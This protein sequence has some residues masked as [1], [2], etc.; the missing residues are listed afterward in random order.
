MPTFIWVFIGGGLGSICRY[1]IA[2]G[3]KSYQFTFPYATLLANVLA[4]FILGTMVGGALK[5]DI[6]LSYRLLIMTGFC[7]GFSTF[8]TFTYET[9][10]LLEQGKFTFALVNIGGSLFVCLVSIYLGLKIANNTF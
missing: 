10:A 3:L 1:G 8:S 6:D 4:C 5:T 7:G 2:E 9:F